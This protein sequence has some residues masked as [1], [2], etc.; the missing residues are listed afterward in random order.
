MDQ[1]DQR[2]WEI[3][4][5][6]NRRSH[7]SPASPRIN[8]SLEFDAALQGA[9]DSARSPAAAHCGVMTLLDDA[10][11]CRPSRCPG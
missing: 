9:L 10:G 5:L 1:S 2:D 3:G 7:L 4:A 8:E 6:R 11:G